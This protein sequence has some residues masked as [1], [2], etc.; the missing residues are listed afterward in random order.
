MAQDVV[1]YIK[2]KQFIPNSLN[3]T[4]TLFGDFAPQNDHG[5]SLDYFNVNLTRESKDWYYR[6]NKVYYNLNKDKYRTK[7]FENIDWNNSIVVFGC[8]HVFGTGLEEINTF[9]S[10]IEAKTGIPTIN[11]GTPG[12]SIYRSLND[13]IL[14]A[15]KGF[16][17]KAVV[18]LWT[19]C[20]RAS[21][22][23]RDRVLNI[24]S[25]SIKRGHVFGE[26][27]C[28]DET[29]PQTHA[30][31]AQLITKQIWQTKTKYFEG[32]FF[33]H[34]SKLLSCPHF[35]TLDRGRDLMHPGIKSVE[36]ATEI[37]VQGL[38]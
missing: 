32:S 34:T 35:K 22:Y 31:F 25:W 11:M 28:K 15:E 16:T 20:F 4:T 13:S 30:L 14:L 19:D 2:Q 38:L 21:I 23:E 33:S 24:G 29:N 6:D 3:Y 26:L 27:W 36:A 18:F 7:D 37:I 8:S 10:K 5:D 17:P 12:G 9:S 1:E